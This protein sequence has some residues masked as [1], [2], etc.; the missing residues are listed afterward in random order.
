M[1]TFEFAQAFG[2]DGE[3]VA[4]EVQ[5]LEAPHLS[6]LRRQLADAISIFF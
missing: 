6:D 4:G 2:E 1:D 5:L 3:F